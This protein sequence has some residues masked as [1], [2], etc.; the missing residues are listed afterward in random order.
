MVRNKKKRVAVAIKNPFK[1]LALPFEGRRMLV[2]AGDL[3]G[4]QSDYHLDGISPLED[5]NDSGSPLSQEP[6]IIYR[7]YESRSSKTAQS[8]AMLSDKEGH[9]VNVRTSTIANE[10]P[11]G[12]NTKSCNRLTGDH[13]LMKLSH[14]GVNHK[15]TDNTVEVIRKMQKV[16]SRQKRNNSKQTCTIKE[17]RSNE[18]TMLQKIQ[19][20][21]CSQ[22]DTC[23]DTAGE[24]MPK[25][26]KH[27]GTSNIGL[28]PLDA[29]QSQYLGINKPILLQNSDLRE[30]PDECHDEE[31]CTNNLESHHNTGSRN[32]RREPSNAIPYQI[33]MNV[34]PETRTSTYNVRRV[35]QFMDEDSSKFSYVIHVSCKSEGDHIGNETVAQQITKKRR[36]D[37]A[38]YGMFTKDSSKAES[39]G[40]NQVKNFECVSTEGNTGGFH[41]LTDSFRCSRSRDQTNEASVLEYQ[42]RS[43]KPIDASAICNDEKSLQTKK[44]KDLS[45]QKKA[46]RRLIDHLQRK[47]SLKEESEI[48]SVPPLDNTEAEATQRTDETS[49]KVLRPCCRTRTLREAC[50]HINQPES[51]IIV[52]R[53][54]ISGK[55]TRARENGQMVRCDAKQTA[56]LGDNDTECK[57]KDKLIPLHDNETFSRDFAAANLNENRKTTKDIPDS[58]LTASPDLGCQKRHAH[59]EDSEAELRNSQK[60]PEAENGNCCYSQTSTH[61]KWKRKTLA[62]VLEGNRKAGL[63]CD[64]ARYNNGKSIG[65]VKLGSVQPS[66]DEP[67]LLTSTQRVK[68]VEHMFKGIY[69]P[70]VTD[71]FKTSTGAVAETIPYS[72]NCSTEHS[73]TI[74]AERHG[75]F[76]RKETPPFAYPESPEHTTPYVKPIIPYGRKNKSSLESVSNNS[77]TS[78]DASPLNTD[79]SNNRAP[80]QI[81]QSPTKQHSPEMNIALQNENH[82]NR[83]RADR[84]SALYPG[85]S[86]TR[87]RHLSKVARFR[88]RTPEPDMSGETTFNELSR[89]VHDARENC[90]IRCVAEHQSGEHS[91]DSTTG[92][93]DCINTSF[94]GEYLRCLWNNQ[95]LCDVRVVVG[96]EEMMVH[97]LVLAAYSFIFC[98][99][100]IRPVPTHNV[101]ISNSTPEAVRQIFSYMYTHNMLVTEDILQPVLNAAMALGAQEIV[102]VVKHILSYPTME[103]VNRYSKIIK[104]S[105]LDISLLDQEK[106]YR[107]GFGDLKNNSAFLNICVDEFEGILMDPEVMVISEAEVVEMIIS[108][109]EYNYLQRI[110]HLDLLLRNVNFEV[111]PI[112]DLVMLSEKYSHIFDTS[113][114]NSFM[115]QAFKYHALN[116]QSKTPCHQDTESIFDDATTETPMSN[117]AQDSYRSPAVVGQPKTGQP[118]TGQ[119]KTGHPMAGQPKA[120]QS[121]GK[122][123]TADGSLQTIKAQLWGQHMPTEPSQFASSGRAGVPD[124]RTP[125][126]VD[127]ATQRNPTAH[128]GTQSAPSTPRAIKQQ[129]LPRQRYASASSKF[130]S[131][132]PAHYAPV[133]NRPMSPVQGKAHSDGRTTP[134]GI[135]R[136]PRGSVDYRSGQPTPSNMTPRQSRVTFDSKFFNSSHHNSRYQRRPSAYTDPSLYIS[137]NNNATDEA[138]RSFLKGI[139]NFK[140][141]GTNTGAREGDRSNNQDGSKCRLNTSWESIDSMKE[142]QFRPV[143]Q[144]RHQSHLAEHFVS[145][146]S[147]E[148]TGDEQ[149]TPDSYVAERQVVSE[150]VT[151]R[152]LGRASGNTGQCSAGIR[153]VVQDFVDSREVSQDTASTKNIIHVIKSHGDV[154]RSF[155]I[156]RDILRSSGDHKDV[157]HDAV[158][159]RVVDQDTGAKRNGD[160]GNITKREV[161]QSTV[162]DRRVDRGIANRVVDPGTST[163]INVDRY[164]LTNR[165]ADKCTDTYRDVEEGVPDA[166]GTPQMSFTSE[167]YHANDGHKKCKISEFP[168]T[169]PFSLKEYVKANGNELVISNCHRQG[170]DNDK[171]YMSTD[172]SNAHDTV[173]SDKPES[174]A[175]RLQKQRKSDQGLRTCKSFDKKTYERSLCLL[176]HDEELSAFEVYKPNH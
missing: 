12:K 123:I 43:D 165:G 81:S 130:T 63:K 176:N 139:A 62:G 53:P 52:S 20:S 162:V 106:L 126:T 82:S 95:A 150:K 68:S 5:H 89:I 121:A 87:K 60:N 64:F 55:T 40:E 138:I 1:E 169:F 46:T 157:A 131:P 174:K 108:W 73:D 47:E 167:D 134:T 111:I 136:T 76:A 163:A 45:V 36:G 32:A 39:S 118:K 160:R 107:H 4:Q 66:R 122:G 2:R 155:R 13:S 88:A 94:M 37:I 102:D 110:G 71:P 158:A 143:G 29:Q 51:S 101:E 84:E 74:D 80:P 99:P 128:K 113:A 33:K 50:Y 133:S 79:K 78:P 18:E 15:N 97:K 23:W 90:A 57:E 77:G 9:K 28:K 70:E 154:D 112:T 116:G 19:Q 14:S 153:E 7:N 67:V 152:E 58:K 129:M 25:R 149:E 146:F 145:E 22:D 34:T 16:Y 96:D 170:K 10:N 83:I 72:F 54:N 92:I 173:G 159:R 91:P 109:I 125:Q 85:G 168:A 48:L 105:G 30:A 59:T 172:Q 140:P 156:Y 44:R 49:Q 27:L 38:K 11:Y 8:N 75:T 31:P 141:I 166:T 104:E 175:T 24:S 127:R 120:G 100:S 117:M 41:T 132:S 3:R 61:H 164:T 98:P 42:T 144:G 56:V 65:K 151:D 17:A 171:Q 137:R 69:R 142:Q 93:E 115:C 26:E 86:T 161:V 35:K 124:S 135:I 119:P 147:S 21:K 114:G 6:D 148:S 103:N